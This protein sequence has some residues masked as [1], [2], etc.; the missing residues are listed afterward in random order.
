MTHWLLR[1]AA[2]LGVVALLLPACARAQAGSSAAPVPAAATGWT[3]SVSAFP[4]ID[5]EGR[6][7]RQ[8]F[9]GGFDVPRPQLADIDGDGDADLFVQER[10][11]EVAFY[12]QTPEGFI[13]RTD[14]W[15]D[16]DVGEWYR[17]VDLDGDGDMDLL[18]ELRHSY[19]RA[20][21]NDG[22]RTAPRLVAIGDTL[23]DATGAPIFADRQNILNLTD[24]DCNGRLDLF[25]GRVT[26]TI[27]RYEAEPTLG[28]DGL[29][30]FRFLTERWEG[31]EI[32]GAGA[33]PGVAPTVPL[34][35]G[36]LHGA[37][38]MAFGDV[39]GDGDIDLLWGD[40]FE[41]GLL[42]IA[43][44]D[45]CPSFS[46]RS[47]P[48]RFPVADPVLTSGYN[49]PTVGDIDGDGDADVVMGVIGGAFNPSRTSIDNLF[50]MEQS[51]PGSYRIA[52]SR[53][54]PTIDVGSEAKPTLGDLDGDGDLDLLVGNKLATDDN[55][56]A[57]L[58]WFENTGTAGSPVFT[59]RGLLPIRGTFSYSP[60]IT[61]LDGD[62][63]PDLVI[64][65]WNDRVQWW[66]NRGTAAAPQWEMVDSALVTLTRGSN[67]APAVADLDGDG[68]LDLLVGESSGQ[69]NL[70]RNV[71]TPTA[72][73]FE[74]VTDDIEGM[75]IGRRSAPVL[76]D[77]DG[78]GRPDLLLGSE[79]GILQ[80]WWNR[81]S[82]GGA[83][84]FER[85]PAFAMQVDGMAAPTLGDLDG[86]GA[87]DLLVGTISGGLRA[88]RT[89]AGN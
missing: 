18:G 75:D 60:V 86:D 16:V 74:L 52:T 28:S 21:R 41:E 12:E 55:T 57:T 1:A 25:I 31:I 6:A 10:S 7:V 62:A 37:N 9:L 17:L 83:I 77:L 39:D 23:R 69:V 22:T 3:A 15:Q 8:P 20:W 45:R 27:D 64:G 46:L 38:T 70:Y 87:L 35:N 43:N 50:L 14:R 76:A 2:P 26:G 42:L 29:L 40:F 89:G 61:D 80:R 66:T 33:Q 47:T 54:I 30:R 36:S 4:V 19:V 81:T 51:A 88:Y 34:P 13:W 78:D 67:A 65:T 68:D 72:P 44:T 63:K 56:T 53:L 24:I 71:G 84:A 58:T 48:V 11:G 85:D 73:R 5:R 79:D 82:P 32:I 59:E 49:A